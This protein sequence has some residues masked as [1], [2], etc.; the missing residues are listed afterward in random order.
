MDGTEKR[1]YELLTRC[2][3]HAFQCQ[4]VKSL[5]SFSWIFLILHQT[6]RPI[7]VLCFPVDVQSG[8]TQ[9]QA[10]VLAYL[11]SRD[12]SLVLMLRCSACAIYKK[13]G[14]EVLVTFV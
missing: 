9:H 11:G 10:R 1:F 7:P 6:R 14:D 13:E 2:Q 12:A 4:E 8:A 5:E 3:I